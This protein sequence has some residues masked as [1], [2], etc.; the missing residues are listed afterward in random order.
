M[1]SRQKTSLLIAI[2]ATF[3]EYILLP[4]VSALLHG[5]HLPADRHDLQ[6]CG[7]RWHQ[8]TVVESAG[9]TGHSS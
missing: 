3:R 7:C 8:N 5:R 1:I 4:A 2:V 6:R 9:G